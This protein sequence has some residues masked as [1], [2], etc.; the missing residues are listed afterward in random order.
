MTDLTPRDNPA[1]S[2]QALASPPPARDLGPENYETLVGPAALD[3]SNWLEEGPED[4]A[5]QRLRV[6]RTIF[7]GTSKYQD[8]WI[9]ENRAFGR[10]FALDGYVQA[11][12][13]DEFIYHEM[14]V[15][16]P[17]FAH[18][19]A[20]DVLIIG[21]GDGG[22]LR[23]V[24]K[25]KSVRR[26]VVVEIDREVVE[27]CRVHLP[28]LS[29][30]AFADPRA[31]VVID[32][33]ASFLGRTSAMF[34]VILVDAP[35]PIGPGRALFGTKFFA[36][37]RARLRPGGVLVAQT[38]VSFLQAMQIRRTISRLRELFRDVSAYTAPVPTYYGG[39]MTFAWA[40][41]AP[42]K[43]VASEDMLAARVAASRV[44]TRC[45]TP[46]LHG[47]SFTLP[48]HLAEALW[49]AAAWRTG[50]SGEPFSALRP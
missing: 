23:E 18:G 19:A 7:R 9:F 24:L 40:S 26:A 50:R 32:D 34:D 11:T 2:D 15:H 44:R 1:I 42:R 49:G 48:R 35:D 39:A 43:F 21:G 13:R 6:D 29:D 17:M 30:G 8:I 22:A 25:H 36:A 20:R 45:Y 16:V 41:D 3:D 14:M 12:E 47:A 38:G 37:C 4:P 28:S 27:L 5:G 31:E 46:A 33:G 10:V